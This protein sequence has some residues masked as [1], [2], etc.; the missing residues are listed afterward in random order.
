LTDQYHD[1]TIQQKTLNAARQT[2]KQQIRSLDLKITD[3]QAQLDS[4]SLDESDLASL[5]AQVE[6][7]ST[8][9]TTAQTEFAA[10]NWDHTISAL[11]LQISTCEE[12]I[13]AVQR[14]LTS[15]SAQSDLRAKIDVLRGDITRKTQGRTAQ[16]QT[17]AAK[18]RK[19]F[20]AELG[21]KTS[22]SQ[23]SILL[24]SRQEELEDAERLLEGTTKETTSLEA[25]LTA[26]REQLK[27]KRKER[28]QSLQTVM[29]KAEP[30]EIDLFPSL[31]KESEY[32][33]ASV[34]LYSSPLSP[35]FFVDGSW[36]VG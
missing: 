29:D 13:N 15:T 35:P 28:S 34:K 17:H 25:K 8:T 3:L 16:I 23:V 26:A 24:R 22:E 2:S 9:L 32:N 33:V 21:E 19:H 1:L 12:E 6:E 10:K 5:K 18:F 31:V 7:T 27:D 36:W 30:D 4:L 20:E 11:E 14:E